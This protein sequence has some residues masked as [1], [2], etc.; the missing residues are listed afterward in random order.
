MIGF[1]GRRPE[2][3][4]GERQ[5]GVPFASDSLVNLKIGARVGWAGVSRVPS[6]DRGLPTVGAAIFNTGN[7]SRYDWP[8]VSVIG[9]HGCGLCA[10]HGI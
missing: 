8:T 10:G 2:A 5:E 3:I 4:C 9:L 1:R 7:R 6:R